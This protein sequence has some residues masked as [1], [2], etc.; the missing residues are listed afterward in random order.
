MIHYQLDGLLDN[1]AADGTITAADAAATKIGVARVIT[2]FRAGLPVDT[3]G[4]LPDFAALFT[5]AIFSPVNSRFVRSDDAIYPPDVAR[6]VRPGTRVLLTCGT[7]DTQVP[8]WT[9]RAEVAVLATRRITGPGLSVLPDVDHFLHPAG[10][11]TNDQILAPVMQR[12]L[13]AFARP[14]VD[15]EMGTRPARLSA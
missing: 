3:S 4:M 12:A 10:T 14:F 13:L 2:E 5:T 6:D 8:C 11:P 1:Q 7:A 9:T 15:P